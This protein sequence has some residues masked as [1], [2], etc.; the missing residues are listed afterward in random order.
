MAA[1]DRGLARGQRWSG[2]LDDLCRIPARACR[3]RGRR[4]RS[5]D[6]GGDET[7]AA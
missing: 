4:R 2:L 6:D 5:E 7:V 3:L 1:L